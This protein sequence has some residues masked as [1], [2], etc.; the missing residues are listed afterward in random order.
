MKLKTTSISSY[1]FPSSGLEEVV[2][3]SYSLSKERPRLREKKLLRPNQDL[4]M[5]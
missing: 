3:K 2:G 4:P 1:L 5:L